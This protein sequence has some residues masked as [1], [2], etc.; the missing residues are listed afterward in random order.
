MLL[1]EQKCTYCHRICAY[2]D[3]HDGVRKENRSDGSNYR[4]KVNE[5][6]ILE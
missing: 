5:D 2:A 6:K 3:M 4:K 1:K